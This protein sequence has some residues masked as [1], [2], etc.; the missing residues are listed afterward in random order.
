MYPCVPIYLA[1]MT[2]SRFDQQLLK[3]LITLRTSSMVKSIN[4][5]VKFKKITIRATDFHGI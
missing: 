1:T 3:Y 4:K 5:T 2:Q